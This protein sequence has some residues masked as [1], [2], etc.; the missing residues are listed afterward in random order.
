[1][2][3]P[4][5]LFGGLRGGLAATWGLTPK[6]STPSCNLSLFLCVLQMVAGAVR[7]GLAGCDALVSAVRPDAE[8]V[9]AQDPATLVQADRGPLTGANRDC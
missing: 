5:T 2:Q 6:G 4:S 3:L 1:M 9:W 8:P 7:G